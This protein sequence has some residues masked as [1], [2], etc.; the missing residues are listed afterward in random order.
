[1]YISLAKCIC[2]QKRKHIAIANNVAI[3]CAVK[4][5]KLTYIMAYQINL[6]LYLKF[7]I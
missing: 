2:N 3:N 7:K 6:K 4:N 1:M 5:K